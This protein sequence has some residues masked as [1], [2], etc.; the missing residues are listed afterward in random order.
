[1]EWLQTLDPGALLQTVVA[2]VRGFDHDLY[3]IV[4]AVAII[5]GA[6]FALMAAGAFWISR[7]L[8]HQQPV[9]MANLTPGYHLV[10]GKARGPMLESPFTG[11]PC[12]WWRIRVWEAGIE[13][14]ERR[15][16]DGEREVHQEAVWR[17]QRHEVS[18]QPIQCAEGLLCCSVQPTGISLVV[19]S[20]VREWEGPGPEPQERN[21][22][23]RRGELLSR[24]SSKVRN[25]SIRNGELH[26]EN[27]Y[28]YAEEIIV[29]GSD[30][31]V[32]GQ[33]DRADGTPVAAS[34]VTVAPWRIGLAPGGSLLRQPCMLSVLPPSQVGGT[35]SRAARGA[36]IVAMIFLMLG[37]FTIWARLGGS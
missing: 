12:V 35:F 7:P 19:P 8:R 15:D 13:F 3:V 27:P 6:V 32:L 24:R 9:A 21:P 16:S 28:R 1:M 14:T 18:D 34:E 25:Y 5:M 22:P 26:C 4:L 20:E 10:Q 11:R 23:M 33:V 2:W 37:A 29:P 31:F 17:E 30:L 36:A